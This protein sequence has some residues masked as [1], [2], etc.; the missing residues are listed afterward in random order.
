MRR[1][2]TCS[3]IFEIAR[4]GY[5]LISPPGW[6]QLFLRSEA[7]RLIETSGMPTSLR[8]HHRGEASFVQLLESTCESR[9]RPISVQ[10]YRGS[11]W[12]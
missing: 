9:R 6:G 11:D 3:C 2:V 5:A 7:Q 1:S 10:L 4:A 8:Q 12:K